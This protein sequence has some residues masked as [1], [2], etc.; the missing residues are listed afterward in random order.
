VRVFQ[1]LVLGNVKSVLGVFFKV[2]HTEEKGQKKKTNT[3]SSMTIEDLIYS[4][5]EKKNEESKRN[6]DNIFVRLNFIQCV[7]ICLVPP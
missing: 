1:V 6:R 5:S 7:M 4:L 2:T 3:I